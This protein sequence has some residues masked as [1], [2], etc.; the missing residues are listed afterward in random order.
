MPRVS[1]DTDIAD[2]CTALTIARPWSLELL[3]GAHARV[4]GLSLEPYVPGAYPS[5]VCASLELHPVAEPIPLERSVLHSL[6]EPM[7]SHRLSHGIA[8]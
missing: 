4:P 1:L 5:K 2:S 3:P 8:L 7:P 6:A